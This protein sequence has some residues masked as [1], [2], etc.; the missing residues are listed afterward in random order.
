MYWTLTIHKQYTSLLPIVDYTCRAL[1]YILCPLVG[2]TEHHVKNA[3]DFS[4]Y[5]AGIIIEKEE[6]FNSHD[7]VFLF[8][9]TPIDK[10][11]DVICS[12]L[13]NVSKFKNRTKL[14]I[15]DIIDLFKFVRT[16]YFSFCRKIY[17]Q[18]FG[19]AVCN[20]I[21][22][23]VVNLYKEFLEQ[24]TIA[25]T[26]VT[27]ASRLWKR[28]VEYILEI[29]KK[30]QEDNLTQQLNQADATGSIKFT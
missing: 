21:S 19:M 18:T 5:M 15:S 8:T 16:T 22:P 4:T 6:V 12:R 23:I 1:A 26:S 28:H 27:C 17:K 25:T 20:S 10:A 2:T 9:N 30:G 29:S 24:H 11:L 3:K 14:L 7:V 13:K